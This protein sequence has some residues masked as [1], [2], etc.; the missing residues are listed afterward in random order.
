SYEEYHPYGTSAYRA[1]DSSIDVSAKRYR[2]TGMERD[3]ETGLA[4]HSARYYAS[5]LGR[6]TASDPIG[7]GDG[8]NRYSYT[9]G[10]P[11]Q[12]S[13]L[14]GMFLR[15]TFERTQRDRRPD[16]PAFYVAAVE[17]YKE[18]QRAL[19]EAQRSGD[20]AKI[21]A[22]VKRAESAQVGLSH[23]SE[24]ATRLQK[25]NERQVEENK[26]F[27]D[28]RSERN[29]ESIHRIDDKDLEDTLDV[30][31]AGLDALSVGMDATGVGAVVSWVPDVVN[32]GISLGRGDWVGAGLSALAT[33]PILGIA[34]NAK[35]LSKYGDEVG[36]AAPALREQLPM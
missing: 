31:Q 33:V 28:Q 23:A 7:L 25:V 12:S 6:W 4:Y 36:D 30:T 8:V 35:R 3:E 22:A 24:A 11:S 34:A 21:E 16:A 27:L 17:E 18:A 14:T 9:G 26:R 5:W 15:S 19:G 1:V 20:P 32:A 2:Y 13:D 10:C 29:I